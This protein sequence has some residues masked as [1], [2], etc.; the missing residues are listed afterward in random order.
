MK[1]YE[2]A[3][4]NYES[5]IALNDSDVNYYIRPMWIYIDQPTGKSAETCGKS[6]GKIQT[7]PWP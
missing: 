6:S 7:P 2:N 5:V 1:A 3:A 4:K